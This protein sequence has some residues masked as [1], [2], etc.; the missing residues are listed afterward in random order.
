MS[1]QIETSKL[2]GEKIKEYLAKGKRFDGRKPDNFREIFIETGVSKNAEGS[3]RVKIG[4]TEVLVG[5]KMDVGEPYPDSA[6]A[7]NLMVNAE[8]LPLSSPKFEMGP[9][10]FPSVELARVIDRGIRESK[11]IDLKGLCIKEGEKVWT[12]AIDIYSINNDGNLLD[13]AG[14]GALAA[15]KTAKIPKYDE[16]TERVLYGELTDK[17]IPLSKETPISITVHKIG[18]GLILDPNLEE[19]E[20]SEMKLTISSSNGTVFAM[21]KGELKEMDV[22]DLYKALDIV[23]NAEKEILKKLNHF[24]K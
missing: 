5:I 19:E 10:K 7:G 14:L 17:S 8:L 6:D 2:T 16:E 1:D 11:F 4:N 9:P 15:L 21:Q 12:V 22:E 3:A 18:N 24:V 13:A 23:E 20:I